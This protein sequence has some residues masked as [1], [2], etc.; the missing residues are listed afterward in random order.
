[1]YTYKWDT[2]CHPTF[3]GVYHGF[4]PNTME[5]S[6][7]RQRVSWELTQWLT[8]SLERWIIRGIKKIA[9]LDN[10]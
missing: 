10:M 6:T 1:M 5:Y 7:I 4:A 8:F 2:S 9:K 3:A